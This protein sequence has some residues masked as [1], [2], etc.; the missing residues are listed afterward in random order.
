MTPLGNIY[1][2]LGGR[3]NI[4]EP[5]LSKFREFSTLALRAEYCARGRAIA[6]GLVKG[7]KGGL[8][9]TQSG[10]GRESESD[11]LTAPRRVR[12]SV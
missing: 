12:Q 11:C 7:V 2:P 9:A 5:Y 6:G 10:Q 8:A 4:L 1:I 3:L